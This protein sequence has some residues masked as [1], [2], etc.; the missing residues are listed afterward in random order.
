MQ[1]AESIGRLLSDSKVL[2]AI[3]GSLGTALVCLS[4]L[5]VIFWLR[6]C[7]TRRAEPDAHAVAPDEK[8]L[9]AMSLSEMMRVLEASPI[10][11]QADLQPGLQ[12]DFSHS[13]A[14]EASTHAEFSPP[15]DLAISPTGFVTNGC[16]RPD[17][18]A[19]PGAV[20]TVAPAAAA[21][22]EEWTTVASCGEAQRTDS[23]SAALERINVC[24]PQSPSSTAGEQRSQQRPP[25][26][27]TYFL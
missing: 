8:E 23:P 10:G 12:P 19:T 2:V 13:A 7:R 18:T 21:T 15:R 9:A 5:C 24:R 3:V 1:P 11:L 4:V 16:L 6:Q 14:V 26:R 20:Q 25:T 17:F 27:V 22:P